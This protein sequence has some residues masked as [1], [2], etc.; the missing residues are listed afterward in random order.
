MV[1]QVSRGEARIGMCELKIAQKIGSAIVW[2]G[3][4]RWIEKCT[5]NTRQ[6]EQLIEKQKL[7]GWWDEVAGAA[8]GRP[9]H[10]SVL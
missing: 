1:G 3:Y 8:K 9:R 4:E 7:S 5:G 2:Q 6:N 10:Y